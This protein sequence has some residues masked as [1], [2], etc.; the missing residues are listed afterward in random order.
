MCSGEL[1]SSSCSRNGRVLEWSYDSMRV[2]TLSNRSD[3][4]M[5]LMVDG[6]DLMMA[7]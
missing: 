2:I 3:A 4:S 6:I 7:A 5:I 1:A